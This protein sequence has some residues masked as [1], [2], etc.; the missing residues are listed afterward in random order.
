MEITTELVEHLAELSRLEFNE[1]EIEN[2]KKEFAS[3][4]EHVN[5]INKVDVSGVV[6][7]TTKLN[8]ETDLREDIVQNSLSKEQVILNAPE[9]FGSSIAVPTMVD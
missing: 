8:A 7:Q 1:D 9:S 3:T 4:L 5:Q 6:A 2:F